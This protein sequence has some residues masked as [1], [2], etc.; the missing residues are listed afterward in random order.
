MSYFASSAPT[1]A[2]TATDIVGSST[3]VDPI[4]TATAIEL[5]LNGVKP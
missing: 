4:Y 2:A 1:F 5:A 3:T